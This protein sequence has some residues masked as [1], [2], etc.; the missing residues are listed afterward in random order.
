[1]FIINTP[2]KRA[3]APPKCELHAA[4]GSLPCAETSSCQQLWWR[5]RY[6]SY[7]AFRRT[8][9]RI[10]R[11]RELRREK[12]DKSFSKK[13]NK[14]VWFKRMAFLNKQANDVA[15]SQ[16]EKIVKVHWRV[17]VRCQT[18]IRLQ[19]ATA[20]FQN[21]AFQRI[22]A[23]LIT[24]GCVWPRLTIQ[25]RSGS[26]SQI[27]IQGPHQPK[28]HNAGVLLWNSHDRCG[29]KRVQRCRH[30]ERVSVSASRVFQWLRRAFHIR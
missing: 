21:I 13:Q 10:A 4:A 18:P 30:N 14:T 1:V 24:A 7:G 8:R 28:N 29:H 11:S 26:D 2:F 3:S 27:P 20:V 19:S 12:L 6:L 15:R 23:L 22:H 9:C 17:L 16:T 25:Q 5:R